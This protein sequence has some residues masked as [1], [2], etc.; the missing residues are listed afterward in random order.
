MRNLINTPIFVPS[1]TLKA[2]QALHVLPDPDAIDQGNADQTQKEV[3]NIL[4]ATIAE[5][6]KILTVLE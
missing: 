6:K 1:F 2:V 3:C 5:I 4:R